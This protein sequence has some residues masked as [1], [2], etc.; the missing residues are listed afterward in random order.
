M[1]NFPP[2]KP[3]VTLEKGDLVT[4][5]NWDGSIQQISILHVDKDKDLVVEQDPI[6]GHALRGSYSHLT[7]EAVKIHTPN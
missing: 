6:T 1:M 4:V 2:P 3:G 5:R 7:H